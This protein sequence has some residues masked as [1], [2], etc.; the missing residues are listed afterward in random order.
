[1]KVVADDK[2]PYLK[3]VLEPYATVAYVDGRSIAPH[4]VADA[5]ALIVRTRTR[6]DAA[7]LAQSPVRFIASATIGF[8]HIDTAF[9]ADRGI[10]WTNAAGC[11]SSSVQQYV[12]AV[13]A[14]FRRTQHLR[15]ADTTIGIVGVGHVGSKVERLARALGMRVLRNDPPRARREGDAGFVSLDHVV[16]EADIITFHV[17][18]QRAGDDRTF[19]IADA[20]LLAR[21]RSGQILINTSRGEVIDTPALVALLR[22]S[23]LRACVLDVWENEPAINRELLALVDVATPHIAGYSAD[24]KANGT[25]MSVQAVSRAFG[26]P[27]D[28]WAPTDVPLPP[29]T[30]RREDCANRDAEDVLGALLAATY[31]IMADDRLLRALPDTFEQQRTAHPLRREWPL[32][33]VS[34]PHATPDLARRVADLGFIV[35]P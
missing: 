23:P 24:G 28:A 10:A 8:D 15:F 2:I 21:L 4:H 26:L 33:T 14:L 13:L 11:N 30:A 9:C 12:G 6:C 7:L 25:A 18:L 5:D 20:A 1:M 35:T 29:D 34:L 19:H 17:P 22:R 3:G 31:D 16:A 27:L 32:Y